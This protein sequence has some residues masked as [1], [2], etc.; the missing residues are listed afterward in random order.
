MSR[1]SSWPLRSNRRFL[2]CASTESCSFGRDL[3]S[4]LACHIRAWLVKPFDCC[5]YPDWCHY[6]CDRG[7]ER[8][9][10][11]LQ[12]SVLRIAGG[13]SFRDVDQLFGF[14]LSFCVLF[15][16]APTHSEALQCSSS[17]RRNASSHN[18]YKMPKILSH[19][20]AWLSRPSTGFKLFQPGDKPRTPQ[21][22]NNG[23]GKKMDYT[24]PQ[25][26][27][28]HRGTEIFFV[29]GN[30]LRWSDLVLLKEG[31]EEED[32]T[33]EG[34]DLEKYCKVEGIFTGGT[35]AH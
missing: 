31:E 2:Y 33:T 35:N 28:V 30:E 22:L 29:V 13:P 24:G 11:V 20:P 34:G 5:P 18:R 32:V 9:H 26:T 12:L 6:L 19:T 25:R 27:V 16:H 15:T 10:L 8:L 14:T 4:H 1:P 23:A 3:F 7:E 21:A 17:V